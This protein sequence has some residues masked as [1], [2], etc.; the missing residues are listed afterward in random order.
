MSADP[1]TQPDDRLLVDKP[2]TLTSV[3]RAHWFRLEIA[4]KT[5][6]AIR[7]GRKK[8]YERNSLILW[9][10]LGCPCREDFEAH[11]AQIRRQ[12]SATLR[13]CYARN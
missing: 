8:L 10:Q 4:G 9:V 11:L 3:S 2:W 6:R 1:H 13:T 7:L 5:P 12:T